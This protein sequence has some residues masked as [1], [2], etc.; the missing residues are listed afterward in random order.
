MMIAQWVW[1]GV[2]ASPELFDLEKS[3]LLKAGWQCNRKCLVENFM[4]G[5]HLS[6]VHPKTLRGYTPTRLCTKG[7]SNPYFTSYCADYPENIP[8]ANPLVSLSLQPVDVDHFRVK[9]TL[10]VYRDGLND[11]AIEDRIALWTEVNGEDLEKLEKL[12]AALRSSR[13]VAGPLAGEDLEGAIRDL[14]KYLA[15]G[16]RDTVD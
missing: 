12:Q 2:Y 1:R 4:E 6:V 15:R 7:P 10:S 14:H 16:F 8:P 5:Y 3:T 9:W 13:A 11:G